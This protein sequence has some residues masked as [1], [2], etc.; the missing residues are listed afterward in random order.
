M[1][2]HEMGQ[3]GGLHV[4]SWPGDGAGNDWSRPQ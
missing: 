1:G 4:T 2:G 3:D